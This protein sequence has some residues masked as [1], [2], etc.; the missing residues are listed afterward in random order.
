MRIDFHTHIFPPEIRE[1]REKFFPGEP[2]F[3]LL[4]GQPKARMVGASELLEGIKK[5][6]VDK[7]VTFGFPWKSTATAKIHNDYVIEASRRFPES[8]IP[9]ACFDPL[10]DDATKEA[11]RCFDLGFKGVGE[12]AFYADG[13]QT[14]NIRAI[15]PIVELCR[16]KRALILIHANEPVGHNY[17]GK[18]KAG[19]R[20]YYDIAV[21]CKGIPLILAHWGG[22]LFFFNMLKKEARE[23]LHDVYYDTAASPFLYTKDIYRLAI[24]IIGVEKVLYGSDYPLL[25]PGRYFKEMAHAGLDEEEQKK[26]QGENAKRLLKQFNVI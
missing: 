11:A 9:L 26:I 2:A 23:I 21:E 19:L 8:V 3:E 6:G 25:P 13:D 14:E 16:E 7:A 1:N 15:R 12:L 5:D 24:D 4:Y 18:A 20:F 22:G 10:S 17:P